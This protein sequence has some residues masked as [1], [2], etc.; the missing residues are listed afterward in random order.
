MV[1]T[2][3]SNGDLT[4]RLD[5]L[6]QEIVPELLPSVRHELNHCIMKDLSLGEDEADMR[7]NIYRSWV[8]YE[9]GRRM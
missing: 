9:R 3:Q 8:E 6:T 5:K 1:V 2:A 7:R 4:E